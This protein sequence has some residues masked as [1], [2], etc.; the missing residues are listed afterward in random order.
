MDS[1]WEKVRQEPRAF[2]EK[3]SAERTAG[4]KALEAAC[5]GRAEGS[6]EQAWPGRG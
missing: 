1:A 5:V 2:W 6:R 3:M 4:A